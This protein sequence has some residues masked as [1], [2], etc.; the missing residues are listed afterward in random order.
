MLKT[1]FVWW[2]E[3]TDSCGRDR[4]IWE[5]FKRAK[6]SVSIIRTHYTI[7]EISEDI[8]NKYFGTWLNTRKN[9]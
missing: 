8:K 2:E 4:N 6:S 3:E 5:G 1:G 7:F 9:G